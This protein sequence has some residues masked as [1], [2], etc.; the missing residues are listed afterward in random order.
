M[1][2]NYIQLLVFLLLI[3]GCKE[4]TKNTSQDAKALQVVSKKK[5]TDNLNI[6]ILLDLS[7]RINPVKNSNGTM[8][9]YQRDLGYIAAITKA[10][11]NHIMHKKIQKIKDQIQVFIDPEPSDITLNEKI[12]AL[13]LEFN[14]HNATKEYINKI[15]ETYQFNCKDIYETAIKDGKY[16]GSD[17]FN[18]F[19]N[20][21]SN[22]CI[23]KN[24]RNILI[25]LTDGYMYHK[26]SRIKDKNETTYLT[27]KL[28]RGFKLNTTNWK[29]RFEKNNY[30][31]LSVEQN[32]K[33]LEILVLGINPLKHNPFEKD[34][35]KSYW[36]KWFNEMNVKKHQI[37]SADLPIYLEDVIEDF[38]NN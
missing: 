14:R 27:S 32:L 13:K 15:Q 22:Y 12:A 30:G 5:T 28:I 9:Y 33:E 11:E 21:V 6:S 37:K 26:D 7:D 8:E 1:R 36:S 19:K 34:V 3:V 38:I 10:F 29:K 25:I 23:K 17:L 20:K 18:F 2:P 31:F 24:Q 35:I 4:E 16:I